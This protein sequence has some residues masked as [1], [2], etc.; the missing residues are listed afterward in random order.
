[1]RLVDPERI[2]G[3]KGRHNAADRHSWIAAIKLDAGPD[4]HPVLLELAGPLAPRPATAVPL[5]DEIAGDAMTILSADRR[6][7]L[8]APQSHRDDP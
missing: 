8:Q 7:Y 4:G 3:I 1:M 6:G 5:G 2:S